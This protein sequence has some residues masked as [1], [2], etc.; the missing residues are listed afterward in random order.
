MDL[1]L[2]RKANG[3][4]FWLEL[5]GSRYLALWPSQEAALRYKA[6]N[7]ELMVFLPVRLDRSWVVRLGQ[8][9]A[10]EAMR[11]W[12]LD[13]DD[14]SASFE[15]GRIV[16]WRDILRA[17]GYAEAEIQQMIEPAKP[18]EASARA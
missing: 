9:A 13:E 17:A 11:F 8:M 18:A 14:P 7:P 1:Y 3:E 2:M 6:K 5:D 16:Q 12:L 4:P 15:S 10:I